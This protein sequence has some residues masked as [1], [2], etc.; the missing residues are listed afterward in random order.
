MIA[1]NGFPDKNAVHLNP[2]MPSFEF[3]IDRAQKTRNTQK[4]IAAKWQWEEKTVA[5]WDADLAAIE[6]QNEVL[7]AAIAT[8]KDKRAKADELLD[9]LDEWTGEGLTTIRERYRDQPE[10]LATLETLTSM[11]SSRSMKLE[12]ALEWEKAWTLLD[13]SFSPTSTNTLAAFKALR[14]DAI[15]KLKTYHDSE[16]DVTA[17]QNKRT[18]LKLKLDDANTSWYKVATRICQPGTVEGDLIRTDVPTT[19]ASPAAKPVVPTPAPTPA[20]AP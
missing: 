4:A 15:A 16:S 17:E 3:V 8:M 7:A 13:P 2:I 9:Q 19:T 10:K 12:E 18:K 5:Q 11:G 20:P 6:A 14:L 1:Q